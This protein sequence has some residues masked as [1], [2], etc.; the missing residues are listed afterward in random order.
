MEHYLNVV[1]TSS[2]PAVKGLFNCPVTFLLLISRFMEST[3]KD[4][5]IELFIL[6]LVTNKN[7]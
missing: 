5:N 3:R 1:K 4:L 7:K 2:S 6:L